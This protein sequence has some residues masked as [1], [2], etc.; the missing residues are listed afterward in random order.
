MRAFELRGS[1]GTENLAIVERPVPTPGPEDV[2]VR[3]RACSLNY[4]DL[5]MIRGQYNPRQPLPLGG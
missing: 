4:R 2:R 1:F 3:I 5:L